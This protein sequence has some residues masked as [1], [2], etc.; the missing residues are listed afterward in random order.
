MKAIVQDKYGSP[1]VLE[2]QEIDKPEPEDNEV[3]VQIHASSVNKGVWI[4]LTGKPYAMRLAY[5]PF[6]PKRKIPGMD[7]AGRVEAVG[8]NVTQFQPG[9][10]VFVRSAAPM[11]S[12][13]AFPKSESGGNRP[14]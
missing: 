2:L 9:D 10:E 11:L 13:S 4:I 7:M 6:R 1:D 14:T 8:S 3:L 12:T 5:G